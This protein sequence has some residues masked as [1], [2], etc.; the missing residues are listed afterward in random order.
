MREVHQIPHEH[1]DPAEGHRR[2]KNYYSNNS[3]HKQQVNWQKKKT[4]I[5]EKTV[6]HQP[7][8]T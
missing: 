5:N 2:E 8:D 4:S 7:N 1:E 3:E 6:P